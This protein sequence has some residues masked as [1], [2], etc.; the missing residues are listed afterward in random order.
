MAVGFDASADQL[1]RT[2]NLPSASTAMTACGWVRRDADRN[3]YSSILWFTN[4]G[5][6]SYTGLAFNADGTTLSVFGT[7]TGAQEGNIAAGGQ[8]AQGAW[9]FVAVVQSGTTVTA[10]ASPEG[11]TSFYTGTCT[12]TNYTPAFFGAGNDGTGFYLNGAMQYIRVFNSALSQANLEAEKVATAAV[13]AELFDWR[14][15]DNTDTNDISGNA[16]NPTVGGALTTQ[17]G[18]TI[19]PGGTSYTLN[20]DP[21][22]TA[23]L[24]PRVVALDTANVVQRAQLAFTGSNVTLVATGLDSYTLPVD[25]SD[26]TATGQAIP[27]QLTVPWTIAT[28]AFTGRDITLTATGLNSYSLTVEEADITLTGS[29]VTLTPTITYTLPVDAGTLTFTGQDVTLTYNEADNYVLQIDRGQL[30]I[31]GN[32]VDLAGPL[33]VSAGGHGSVMRCSKVVIVS[34]TGLTKWVNYLPV[35]QVS[36]SQVDANTFASG[37]ALAVQILSSGTGLTPWVDYIPVVEVTDGDESRWRYDNN[38]WI[39]IVEI[40]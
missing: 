10:Y 21:A 22:P 29:T 16:R 6:A 32:N 5:G 40:E 28:M 17:T 23:T 27:F 1:S 19:S 8:P 15:N 18:P 2:T 14:C 35:K 24:T 11:S 37:G 12:A 34:A 20:T 9:I 33:Q 3:D 25:S 7:G 4:S 13:A 26:I 38:G 30:T 31:R 36:P 39:P